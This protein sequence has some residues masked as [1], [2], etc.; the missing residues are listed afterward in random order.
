[1]NEQYRDAAL[2]AINLLERGMLPTGPNP[3]MKVIFDESFEMSQKVTDVVTCITFMFNELAKLH[4]EDA[5][6]I[7]DQQRTETRNA[8][9]GS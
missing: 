4:P 2:A 9:S 3:D 7:I 6:A 5:Q 8:P 1:M